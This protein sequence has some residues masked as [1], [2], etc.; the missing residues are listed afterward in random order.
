MVSY[1]VT[2]SNEISYFTRLELM[3]VSEVNVGECVCEEIHL[4]TFRNVSAS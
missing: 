3:A 1:H 4:K 2:V